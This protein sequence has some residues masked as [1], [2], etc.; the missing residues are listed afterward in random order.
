MFCSFINN[1][2]FLDGSADNS[3]VFVHP[4]RNRFPRLCNEQA[5]C[6][7]RHKAAFSQ[8]KE[9]YFFQIYLT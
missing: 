2:G 7:D 1:F 6:R 9:C 3:L 5:L 8:S 4:R